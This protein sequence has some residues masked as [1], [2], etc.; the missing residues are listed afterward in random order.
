MPKEMAQRARVR[1]WIDFCNTRLQQA[2]SEIRHGN[3]PEKA[4]E[5]LREHLMTLDREMTRGTYIAGDYSLAD[6]T[7]IPFFVR[8]QRY[9]VPIDDSLPHLKR[10]MEHLLA[11]PAVSS[12]L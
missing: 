6:I 9:G 7:F 3:E 11:R 10:W 4:R 2:A 12:T 1:I 5:K 8:Q